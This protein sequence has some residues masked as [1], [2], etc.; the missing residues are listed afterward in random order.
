MHDT[1]L[2]V[3]LIKKT[4][5]TDSLARLWM[6]IRNHLLCFL[7]ILARLFLSHMTHLLILLTLSYFFLL[8]FFYTVIS[9]LLRRVHSILNGH[10]P[11]R[12]M[13]NAVTSLIL[14]AKKRYKQ[15]CREVRHCTAICCCLKNSV[16]SLFIFFLEQYMWISS[17]WD[18]QS[19]LKEKSVCSLFCFVVSGRPNRLNI[20]F[21]TFSP[22]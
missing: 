21:S 16:K 9:M 18:N 14:L 19:S 5:L 7:I 8:Y 20:K 2:C 17:P 3:F 10:P 11:I 13:I 4:D 12:Q 22:G 6:N 15:T 1:L